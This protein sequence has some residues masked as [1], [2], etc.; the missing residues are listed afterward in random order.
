MAETVE[1]SACST[2]ETDKVRRPTARR[3]DERTPGADLELRLRHQIDVS[4]NA[5]FAGKIIELL[6]EEEDTVTVGADLFVLEAG[7]GG[8]GP[9]LPPFLV[10]L[11]CLPDQK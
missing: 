8:S 6:A 1:T 2:I 7:E 4:V 9:S 11:G 10:P 5:P 3:P